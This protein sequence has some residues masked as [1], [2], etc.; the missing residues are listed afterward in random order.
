MNNSSL[1]FS[2]LTSSSSS[3]GGE[4]VAVNERN[5][6]LFKEMINGLAPFMLGST[7]PGLCPGHF[8]LEQHHKLLCSV[9]E[10]SKSFIRFVNC[11]QLSFRA[12]LNIANHYAQ[13]FDAETFDCG[14]YKWLPLS[15]I[16]PTFG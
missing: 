5:K 11:P 8:F 13:E 12:M 6:N 7:L 1:Y 10:S 14:T 3:I 9:K 4:S 16:S 2:I 15:T